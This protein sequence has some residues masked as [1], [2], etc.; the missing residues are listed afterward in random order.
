MDAEVAVRVILS[1][2]DGL[3]HVHERRIDGKRWIHRDV[4]PENVLL[5]SEGTPLLI[6]FGAARAEVGEHSQ[7]MT[8]VLTPGYAPYEQYFS[9]GKAQG[10]WVDVYGT[11]ATLYFALTGQVPPTSVERHDATTHGKADPLVPPERFGAAI[12]P[13]IRDVLSKGLAIDYRLRPQNANQYLSLFTKATGGTTI[14]PPPSRRLK[15]ALLAAIALGAVAT[16]A[17]LLWPWPSARSCSDAPTRWTK[18][19]RSTRAAD[20]KA[21]LDEFSRCTQASQARLRYDEIVVWDALD[22]SSLADLRRFMQERPDGFLAKRARQLVE[23]A[24]LA[25]AAAA[26]EKAAQAMTAVPTDRMS[27]QEYQ[28]AADAFARAQGLFDAGRLEE[29]ARLFGEARAQAEQLRGG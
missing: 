5:R 25:L 6:D 3:R 21:F 23:Q 17:Y 24:V 16:F 13:K 8:V 7:S 26:Q 9:T 18:I 20:Y 2:L 11:A 27:T 10:P 29:A 19:E 28:R 4:K 14:E 12:S 15:T 22:K 1:V